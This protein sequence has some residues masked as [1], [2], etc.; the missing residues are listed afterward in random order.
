MTKIIRIQPGMLCNVAA[1]VPTALTGVLDKHWLSIVL[2]PL[3]GGA[4]I[5][6]LELQDVVKA[7]ASKVRIK[8]SFENKPDDFYPLCIK[9]FL[10]FDLGSGGDITTFREAGFY[11]E[12]APH[13]DMV[14]PP[15]AAVVRD[16]VNKRCVIIMADL[17]DE[18][19]HFFNA[20]EPF[21][22]DQVTET[23]DQL[24]RLHARPELLQGQD[25]LPSRISDLAEKESIY[26]W[27]KIQNLM[28]DERSLGLPAATT[29]AEN[30]KLGIEALAAM[31]A[32]HPS[33]ILHGDCHPGNVY[34][35]KS[36]ALGFTDWQLVQKGH[37]SLDVAYHIAASL[38]V[39]LAEREER[40]LLN[41]YLDAVAQ[42]GGRRI[43]QNYAWDLYR[44]APIYGY[45]HWAITQR[46]APPITKQAFQR[47]GAAV[48][49]HESYQRL[50]IR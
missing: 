1:E 10:D 44:C 24:A 33:T 39:D 45:Y 37:W 7:M 49:R 4:K 17:I 23:L 11:S 13:L 2:A 21:I 40:N 43:P 42:Y 8:V 34:R 14:V 29:D 26:P 16:Q 47:L 15:C 32:V 12:I 28:R 22:S 31:L 18:E 50:G 5:A 48:T 35:L 46:V 30:L 38:P 9:G 19:A 3:S 25:W 6:T 41:H 20:L 27:S 36:G